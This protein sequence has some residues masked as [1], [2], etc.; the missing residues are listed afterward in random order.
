MIDFFNELQEIH[1]TYLD[2]LNSII[3]LRTNLA[4]EINEKIIE[5]EKEEKDVNVTQLVIGK[6][7]RVNGNDTICVAIK[8]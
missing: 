2:F 1:F 5:L 3:T 7:F 4:S 8:Y 6:S